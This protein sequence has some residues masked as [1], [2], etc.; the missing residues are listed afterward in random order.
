[1]SVRHLYG[2]DRLID[3][4]DKIKW[5]STARCV[6]KC[7]LFL[8]SIVYWSINAYLSV[9]RNIDK[10]SLLNMDLTGF[11]ELDVI[12]SSDG[13]WCKL[14]PSSSTLFRRSKPSISGLRQ[15]VDRWAVIAAARRETRFPRAPPGAEVAKF[16]LVPAVPRCK[17]RNI[18][19]QIIL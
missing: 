9:V 5:I 16:R 7:L 10:P 18:Q 3:L 4:D 14:H 19:A 1:M 17:L 2:C 11:H 13:S 12:F 15:H 6:A 8:I